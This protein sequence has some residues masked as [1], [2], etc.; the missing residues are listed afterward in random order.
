MKIALIMDPLSKIHINKDTSFALAL[1]AQHRGFQIYYV[2]PESV[3]VKETTPHAICRP[4]FFKRADPCFEVLGEEQRESLEDFDYILI[5]RDPPF[6]EQYFMLTHF[7]SL[8]KKAKV[9]NRP[10]SLREAPEKLYSLQFPGIFPPSLISMDPDEI[11]EFMGVQGGEIIIKPLNRCGGSGI[12]YLH[13]DDKNFCS[14]V[15]LLTQDGKDFILAQ[16]YL[17]EVREGDKRIILIGGEAKGA[18]WRIPAENEHRGNIHVGGQVKLAEINPR[19]QWLVDQLTPRLIK[20]GLYF[21]GLD[22]IGD[23]VTEINVTSP[24]GIQE[25]HQ[26]GGPDLAQTFWDHLPQFLG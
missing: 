16:R 6:D 13:Q 10:A 12:V 7:L 9:L 8:L 3:S 4:V 22:V 14:L 23:W 17:P 2:R 11:R 26:Q 21:V 24:T 15:E 18:I 19:D 20:D 25:I 1:E 5:R